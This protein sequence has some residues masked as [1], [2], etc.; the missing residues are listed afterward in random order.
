[1]RQAQSVNIVYC[2]I[3]SGFGME[4]ENSSLVNA[5]C[6]LGSPHFRDGS[7]GPSGVKAGRCRKFAEEE[8]QDDQSCPMRDQVPHRIPISPGTYRYVLSTKE[9]IR[10]ASAR[11]VV[12]QVNHT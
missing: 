5:V 10:R 9:A 1:M 2:G 4:Q 7:T 8:G 11:S 6:L 3:V 12:T